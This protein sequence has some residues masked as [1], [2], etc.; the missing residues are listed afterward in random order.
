LLSY[1]AQKRI[2]VVMQ[3][4][5]PTRPRRGLPLA[6]LLVLLLSLWAGEIAARETFVPPPPTTLDMNPIDAFYTAFARHD[7]TAMT[8]LYHD[9]V[10]FEDPAFGELKGER[11]KAMWRM[12]LSRGSDLVVTHSN[13]QLNGD[14][15][16]ADWV[17][18]YVF[19]ATKRKVVN[20]IHAEFELKDGKIYRHKDTFD[21]HQWAK[22]AMGFRGWLLG[23]TNFFKK[24]LQGTTNGMLDKYMGK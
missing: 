11:A 20:R 24:K 7:S 13:V 2:F 12:L 9:D 23:G 6:K 17:A 3:S 19:S 10:T 1:S 15:G 14:K 8:Q 18:T 5:S 22:Q 4:N 21:L 16:S